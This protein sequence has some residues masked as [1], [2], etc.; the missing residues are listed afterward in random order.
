MAW[1]SRCQTC[2]KGYIKAYQHLVEADLCFAH[3]N[4]ERPLDFAEDARHTFTLSKVMR[5]SGSLV[6]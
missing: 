6:F 4:E 1:F 2:V 3:D 5:N